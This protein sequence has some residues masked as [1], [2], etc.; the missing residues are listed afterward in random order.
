MPSE[1]PKLKDVSARRISP[2]HPNTMID[3]TKSPWQELYIPP[4]GDAKL[5]LQSRCDSGLMESITS[6][7]INPLTPF[8]SVSDFVRS[9]C[10]RLLHEVAPLLKDDLLSDSIAKRQIIIMTLNA[11]AE[12]QALTEM[13]VKIIQVIDALVKEG[14]FAAARAKVKFV[15]EMAHTMNDPR[16]R[17]KTLALVDKWKDLVK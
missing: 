5:T 7:V 1:K 17:K 15:T 14:D 9:A 8:K 12:G 11:E 4:I 3:D 16:W 10:E 6:L 13:H 2:S